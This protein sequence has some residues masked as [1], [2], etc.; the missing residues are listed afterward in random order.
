VEAQGTGALHSLER[1]GGLHGVTEVPVSRWIASPDHISRVLRRHG[2]HLQRRRSWCVNTDPEFGRK[3]ADI[4]G[5]HL[6][7]NP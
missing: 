3:A 5:L 1:Q 4:V 7:A 2:I 6:L